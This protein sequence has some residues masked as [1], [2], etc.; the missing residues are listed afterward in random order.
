MGF[1][2]AISDHEPLK[3]IIV[4]KGWLHERNGGWLKEGIKDFRG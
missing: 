3:C 2:H 4:L 1:L